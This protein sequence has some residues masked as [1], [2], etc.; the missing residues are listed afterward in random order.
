MIEIK[1]RQTAVAESIHLIW[2]PHPVTPIAGRNLRL[3]E[4][5]PGRT[6]RETLLAAGIDPQQPIVALLDDRLL[7][8]EEWDHVCPK[9]GQLLNV[10]ATVMGGGGGSNPIATVATLA[11]VI[12]APY[13]TTA[14]VGIEGAAVLGSVGVSMVT[15]GIMVAGSM[16]IGAIF[17]PALPSSGYG[18]MAAASPTYSLTGGSNRSRP[19]EPMPVVFG[20]HRLFPDLGNRPYAEFRV[21]ATGSGGASPE[22]ALPEPVPLAVALGTARPN[23]PESADSDSESLWETV[24]AGALGTGSAAANV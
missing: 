21:T 17:P 22:L 19:Y 9:P 3:C 23:D 15:A 8:V 20:T 16:I 6:V 13:L 5:V 18:N 14:L 10:Q 4:W 12:A 24:G 2:H 1:P 7:T 11:L